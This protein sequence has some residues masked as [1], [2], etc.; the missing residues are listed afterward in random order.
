[1]AD[2]NDDTP[3]GQAPVPGRSFEPLAD[4]PPAAPAGAEPTVDQPKKR[5]TP[6]GVPATPVDANVVK[7]F[8]EEIVTKVAT[9][10]KRMRWFANH[11]ILFVVGIAVA[12]SLKL[13]IYTDLEDA[14]FLMPLAAWVGLLAIHAN[15]AMN[16]ILKRSSKEG[17]LKAVIPPDENDRENP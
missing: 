2:E 7:E 8:E 13:S 15:Y 17:E 10:Q 6:R 14:F 12:I 16:P 5:Q 3:V 11:I 9:G 1:M 4:A